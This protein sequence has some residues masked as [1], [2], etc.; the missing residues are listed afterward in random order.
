MSLTTQHPVLLHTA[1]M[2]GPHVCRKMS[3]VGVLS[4]ADHA[5]KVLLHV[6]L[7]SQVTTKAP[8]VPEALRA[9][10]AAERVRAPPVLVVLMVQQGCHPRELLVALLALIGATHVIAAPARAVSCPWSIRTWLA[11]AETSL[12]PLQHNASM[13]FLLGTTC[14]A[15]Y[16][17]KID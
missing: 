16:L 3:L 7:A 13:L 6:V 9:D 12:A 14:L 5:R 15:H 1:A 11:A 10:L 2:A 4:T 8:L 17:C